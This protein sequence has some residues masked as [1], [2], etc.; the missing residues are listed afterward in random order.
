MIFVVISVIYKQR[1]EILIASSPQISKR[2]K[3]RFQPCSN[4][5]NILRVRYVP[6]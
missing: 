1:I 5:D 6:F 2:K 4:K 3:P